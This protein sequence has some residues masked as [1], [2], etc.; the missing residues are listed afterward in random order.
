[1]GY[2]SEGPLGCLFCSPPPHF[3]WPHPQQVEVPRLGV[4]SEV[5]LRPTLQLVA[6]PDP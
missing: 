6:M 4:K 5:H 3:L 1:M 2:S